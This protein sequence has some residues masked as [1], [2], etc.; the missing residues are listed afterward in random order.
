M[1]SEPMTEGEISRSQALTKEIIA[2]VHGYEDYY[3]ALEWS[4]VKLL[5]RYAAHL[6]RRVAELETKRETQPNV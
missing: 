4:D 1:T 2:D 6:E 3:L 5:A